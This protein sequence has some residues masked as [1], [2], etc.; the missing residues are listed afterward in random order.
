MLVSFLQVLTIDTQ[1]SLPTKQE[2]ECVRDWIVEKRHKTWMPPLTTPFEDPWRRWFTALKS[3]SAGIKSVL[4]AGSGRTLY[5]MVF[6]MSWWARHL[7]KRPDGDTAAWIEAAQ[8][9]LDV[10]APILALDDEAFRRETTV[11]P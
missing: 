7:S 2:P 5:D 1:E 6:F 10:L 11:L 8:C 9:L 3:G 4:G